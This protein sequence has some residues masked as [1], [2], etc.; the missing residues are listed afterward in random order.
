MTKP[1]GIVTLQGR[2]PQGYA[3]YALCREHH[4]YSCRVVLPRKDLKP[5]CARCGAKFGEDA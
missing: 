4:G 2:S 1:A 3:T 5:L